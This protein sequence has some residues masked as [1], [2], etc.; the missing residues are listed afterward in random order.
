MIGDRSFF[1]LAANKDIVRSFDDYAL[2]ALAILNVHA[3]SYG[4]A[5]VIADVIKFTHLSFLS[6]RGRVLLRGYG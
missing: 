5:I 4:D 6:P 3:L 2:S 1:S